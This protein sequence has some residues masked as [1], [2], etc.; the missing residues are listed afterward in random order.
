MT[1]KSAKWLPKIGTSTVHV[2]W[3]RCGRSSCRCARGNRHGPYHYRF[4]REDGRLRKRY[5]PASEL[6]RVQS[7]CASRRAQEQDQRAALQGA[8]AMWRGLTTKVRE[9]RQHGQPD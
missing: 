6:S 9:V 5:V 7:A 2:Q 3:V 1:P 8:F 4:W